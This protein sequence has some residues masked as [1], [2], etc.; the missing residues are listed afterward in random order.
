MTKPFARQLL[1]FAMGSLCVAFLPPLQAKPMDAQAAQKLLELRT[2]LDRV[3]ENASLSDADR[4][5]LHENLDSGDPVLVSLAAYVVGKSKGDESDLCAEAE[6]VLEKTQGMP[7]AFLRLMLAKKRTED[8]KTSE[9]IAAI[10]P[11]LR[12]ANPY[13][14]VEAARELA[15][16]DARKGEDAL[17][18]LLSEDSPILKGG[19]FRQL[20]RIGKAAD[21]VP[22]PM[23]DERYELLL[24]IIEKADEK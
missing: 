18:A 20:R 17:R 14:R 5:V 8:R 4:R 9:R 3:T 22:V 10:E 21:A 6:V 7:D 15:K 23:P 11:L 1:V 2:V 12:D 19:A 16:S 13:L 24:S